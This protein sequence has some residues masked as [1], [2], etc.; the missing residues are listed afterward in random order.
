MFYEEGVDR[1]CSYIDTLPEKKSDL[2]MMMMTM[3]I[4][5]QYDFLLSV[6]QLCLIVALVY[7]YFVSLFE[8]AFPL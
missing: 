8:E 7:L 5:M 1:V 2:K 3:V 4:M 6:F